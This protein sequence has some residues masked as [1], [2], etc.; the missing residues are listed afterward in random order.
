MFREDSAHSS[1]L[2]R[3]V[4]RA[5][6]QVQFEVDYDKGIIPPKNNEWNLANDS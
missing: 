3:S 4:I 6:L 5:S 2:P 1:I